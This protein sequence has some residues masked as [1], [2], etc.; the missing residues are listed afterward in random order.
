MWYKNLKTDI[1]LNMEIY[2]ISS[3]FR[4]RRLITKL[5]MMAHDLFKVKGRHFELPGPT[6]AVGS[7]CV[8]SRKTIPIRITWCYTRSRESSC[9]IQENLTHSNHLV[10]HTHKE[11]CCPIQ[12]KRTHSNHL[13]LHPQQRVSV[14]FPVSDNKDSYCGCRTKRFE[15]IRFSCT[16][17]H[18]SLLRV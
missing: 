2:F 16:A 5:R 6:P 3:N 14:C 11:S 13:V 8:R 15:W 7:H 12:E 17:Q 4:K 1:Y 9:P 18:K 10:L